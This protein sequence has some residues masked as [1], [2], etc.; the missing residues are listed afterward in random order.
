MSLRAA[1]PCSPTPWAHLPSWHLS[2]SQRPARS[3]LGR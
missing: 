3:S 2:R 1:M